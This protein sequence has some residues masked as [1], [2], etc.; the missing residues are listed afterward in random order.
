MYLK[1]FGLRELP[2]SITPD[3]SFFFSSAGAQDALSTLLVAARTGEG[4]IKITGE[5]GTGKTLLCRKLIA[6]L[7]KDYKIGYIPNPYLEPR[8]LLL[9]LASELEADV[10][11]D[12][13]QGM[14][15]HQLLKALTLRLLDIIR[16]GKG[17][18]ICLDEVQAMPIETLEAL[19]LLT[20][21]ETEKRKLL[22]VVIFGQPEL[23][24]KL[25]HPSIRQLKQRIAFDYHLTGLTA[26]ELDYYIHHRLMVAGYQ[27]GRLFTPLALWLLRLRTRRVPRLVNILAHKSMLSAYGKGSRQVGFADVLAA[28][29]DTSSMRS[30]RWFGGALP[31]VLLTLLGGGIA[32]IGWVYLR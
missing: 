11:P 22:Q 17:V 3:T 14:D 9:E 10:G 7:Q 16:G 2:F 26:D 27:G 24:D 6:T 13:G 28:A 29:N 31:V 30:S 5:V 25:N 19:R 4:F 12:G 23:E 32:G 18:L 8:A 15:Q 21:L 20:N 1:H